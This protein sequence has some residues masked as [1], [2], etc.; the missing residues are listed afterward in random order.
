MQLN[1]E[2]LCCAAEIWVSVFDFEA[3]GSVPRT[4]PLAMISTEVTGYG[5]K[6]K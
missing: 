4:P 3:A 6:C 2:V 1:A 5:K